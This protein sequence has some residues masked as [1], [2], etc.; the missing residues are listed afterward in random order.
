MHTFPQANDENFSEIITLHKKV[1]IFFSSMSCGN[2]VIAEK[3]LEKI[4]PSFKDIV[5]FECKVEDAPKT[6]E[7]YKITGVPQIRLFQD[8]EPI[9][10]A[11]GTLNSQDLY[12]DLKMI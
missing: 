8:G 10:T 12:Y 9:Y 6:V 3:N 11:F 2:C 4:L 5:V 7:K 1:L